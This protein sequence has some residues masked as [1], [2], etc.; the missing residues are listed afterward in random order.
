MKKDRRVG[1]CDVLGPTNILPK[2]NEPK[3]INRRI[4]I[5]WN[6][7]WSLKGILKNKIPNNLKSVVFNMLQFHPSYTDPKSGP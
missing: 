1:E 6:K 5:T 2:Q 3:K 4:T 7:F